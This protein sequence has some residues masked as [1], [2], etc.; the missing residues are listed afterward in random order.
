MGNQPTVLI[1]RVHP[2]RERPSF[3][4]FLGEYWYKNFDLSDGHVHERAVKPVP[5][6]KN[7]R[8]I[9]N[10]INVIDWSSV[11]D[12]SGKV[13]IDMVIELYAGINTISNEDGEIFTWR[14]FAMSRVPDHPIEPWKDFIHYP[15]YQA[16]LDTLYRPDSKAKWSRYNDNKHK[17]FSMSNMKKEA[18][19]WLRL[20]N[21]RILPL[22]H[23]SNVFKDRACILYFLMMGRPVNIGYWMPEE[24]IRV[25][26][27]MSHRL[28]FGS[29]LTASSLG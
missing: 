24:M 20:F 9:H 13:N 3:H 18:R 29:T 25:R 15:N 27:D 6:R 19:V 11:F 16:I 7:F 12:N 5:L 17:S 22:D 23:Y 26:E 14:T 1:L 10:Q 28:R 4:D 8:D 2:S 21:S